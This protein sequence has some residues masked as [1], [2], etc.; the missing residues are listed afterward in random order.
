LMC[1]I[2]ETQQFLPSL[3]KILLF[4]SDVIR[5]AAKPA[6][7]QIVKHPDDPARTSLRAEF[8]RSADDARTSIR[9]RGDNV[10]A[11]ILGESGMHKVLPVA[12]AEYCITQA[13]GFNSRSLPQDRQPPRWASAG[14]SLL[15]LH[16]GPV[17]RP[18]RS[19]RPT[20]RLRDA[21]RPPPLWRLAC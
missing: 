10:R 19:H 17:Q 11:E 9:F 18:D 1:N 12:L 16:R 7:V 14:R 2:P 15:A 13:E 20:S 5:I 3:T 21:Q 6:L 4:H 8:Y